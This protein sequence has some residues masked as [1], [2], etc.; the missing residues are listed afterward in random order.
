VRVRRRRLPRTD[1]DSAARGARARR[2]RPPPA[3][4]RPAALEASERRATRYIRG[5]RTKMIW[6]TMGVR[7]GA[8]KDTSDKSQERAT[9]N[10][11]FANVL[12]D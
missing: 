1:A 11:H 2:R 6:G 9:A 4:A 8:H 12:C 3:A 7:H 5:L 10:A